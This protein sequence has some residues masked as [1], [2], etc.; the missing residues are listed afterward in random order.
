MDNLLEE[1]KY[2]MRKYG[3][4]ADKK[5]GQNFL[6]NSDI[7]EGIVKGADLSKDD[8][9]IEIGPGLGTLTKYLLEKAGKVMCIELDTRMI[10][11]KDMKKE[12]IAQIKNIHPVGNMNVWDQVL[13]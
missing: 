6:I 7:I 5:L 11:R 1:T 13:C 8:L 12:L 3:V 2:I 4:I 10:C 9:V